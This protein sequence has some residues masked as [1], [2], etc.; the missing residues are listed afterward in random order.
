MAITTR[1][2]EELAKAKS[3]KFETIKS[4]TAAQ[5]QIVKT[6]RFWEAMTS[7]VEV[8]FDVH[9][10]SLQGTE[11]GILA[12]KVE[13]YE[14]IINQIR[15]RTC[16]CDQF[17]LKLLSKP[18]VMQYFQNVFKQKRLNVACTVTT[19]DLVL[20]GLDDSSVSIASD[21]F[22]RELTQEKVQLDSASSAGLSLPQWKEVEMSLMRNSKV[23]EIAVAADKLSVTCCGLRDEVKAATEEL[24]KFFEQN[25]IV[26]QFVQLPEGKVR[27]IQKHLIAF[28][29]SIVQKASQ[30][31]T[32]K[33]EPIEDGERSGFVVRGTRPAMRQAS[34]QVFELSKV[35]LEFVHDSDLLGTQKYFAT[36]RGRD[37]LTAIENRS[38]VVVILSE[39]ELNEDDD[40]VDPFLAASGGKPAV[41]VVKSEVCVTGTKTMIRVVKG[42][43]TYCRADALI[44]TISDDLKHTDGAAR[45]VAM[46]GAIQYNH[47]NLP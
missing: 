22:D 15:S 28:V 39:E 18:E 33:M 24:K 9:V 2:M 1:L 17:K 16:P 26:E 21:A 20:H 43:I 46:A 25:T 32:V 44:I 10:M 41:P 19:K 5:L 27:Y 36:K 47:T 30:N 4:L 6:S 13:L 29:D 37:S 31:G 8:T 40:D 12:V 3:R 42:S 45:L 34:V 35:I 7:D 14:K 11:A 38:K 23:L